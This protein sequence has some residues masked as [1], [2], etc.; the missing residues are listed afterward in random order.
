MILNGFH[1]TWPIVYPEDAYGLARTGQTIVDVTDGSIIRLLVDDEPF[2]LATARM[3]RFE[4]VLDMRIGVVMREVE[5]ETAR[6]RRVL[7]RSRR[8]ASL[9]DRHLAAIDYEVV[10]LDGDAGVTVCSELVTPAPV[11]SDGD[12]RRGKGFAER[13]LVPIAMR[14]CT[15]TALFCFSP[16]A[17]AGS[18]WDAGWQHRIDSPADFTV[19][20]HAEGDGA[21][22]VV[23][24]RPRRPASPCGCRSSSHITGR[25]RRRPATCSDASSA[26]S[27]APA[28]RATTR[29]KPCTAPRSRS[30]GGAATLSSRAIPNSSARS[31]STCSS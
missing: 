11:Q 19:D 10:A 14:A 3:L 29:S 5:W 21:R 26:R 16:P 20:T 13:V 23:A 25:S 24:R 7:V 9:V 27:T 17:T 22:V 12:P 1:E 4:R 31:A 8:L 28:R 6:G 30:S 18:S 2:D 15:A